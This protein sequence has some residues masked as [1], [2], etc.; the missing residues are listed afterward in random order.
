AAQTARLVGAQLGDHVPLR[1]CDAAG[2][3]VPHLPERAELPDEH[4]DFYLGHL[5]EVGPQEAREGA[6]LAREA[7]DRFTGP[8]T[9]GGADRYELVVTHSFLVGWFVRDALDAPVWRWLG[10]NPGNAALTVIRYAPGRVPGVLVLN[11]VSHLP[12][13]LR[14]TDFPAALHV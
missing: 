5:A 12:D 8:V 14:W 1:V 10:L 13:E 6:R 4:A 7:L 9:G 11:D 3:Y 2:D